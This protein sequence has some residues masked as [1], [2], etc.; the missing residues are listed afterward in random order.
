MAEVSFAH[1]TLVCVAI[2]AATGQRK[3]WSS[4]QRQSATAVGQLPT[5]GSRT[6]EPLH[7]QHHSVHLLWTSG[8]AGQRGQHVDGMPARGLNAG[9]PLTSHK[10][11]C[12]LS[13]LEGD[14]WKLLV[15]QSL[16][17]RK[18]T[19]S[20]TLQCS[21]TGPGCASGAWLPRLSMI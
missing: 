7:F 16:A 2:T 19:T 1:C 17:R 10:Q 6:R 3:S 9:A 4:T 13:F 21:S 20:P 5:T 15:C 12:V 14:R 11:S 18:H 8:G